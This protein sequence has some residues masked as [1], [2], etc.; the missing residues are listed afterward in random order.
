MGL[1]S[2]LNGS[3]SVLNEDWQELKEAVQF[4]EI[5]ERSKEQPVVIFKH[6]TSCG[7]SNFAK[8]RI[9]PLNIES[10]D[11]YYLDLWSYRP[12]SNAVADHYGVIHQSPQILVIK[13]GKCVYTTSHHAITIENIE[14]ALAQA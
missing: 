13:D 10:F 9:E 11:F 12:V 2:F 7:I 3:G 14:E 5:D 1:M 8:D 6:S 4:E